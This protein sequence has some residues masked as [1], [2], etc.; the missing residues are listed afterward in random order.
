[1][2]SKMLV[3]LIVLLV[4]AVLVSS[5]VGIEI[6]HGYNT[7]AVKA[8][9]HVFAYTGTTITSMPTSYT[10]YSKDGGAFYITR[11]QGDL[12]GES[13]S[14]YVPANDKI[15]IPAPPTVV[16]GGN[17]TQVFTVSSHTDSVFALPWGE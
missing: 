6:N 14:I 7:L 8:G 2:R 17:Y 1:M 16:S 4:G 5:V 11:M 12:G 9:D 3:L 13:I 10:V 15:T